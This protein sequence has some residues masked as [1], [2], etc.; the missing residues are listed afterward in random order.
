MYPDTD[1]FYVVFR[2]RRQIS[3][4]VSE[5][6]ELSVIKYT[7]SACIRI[8]FRP[9]I[10][11]LTTPAKHLSPL[12]EQADRWTPSDGTLWARQPLLAHNFPYTRWRFD[13]WSG[14]WRRRLRAV[15][16]SRS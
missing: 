6:R 2:F 14:C 12:T 9:E 13:K 5:S 4:S 11:I 3:V 7:A 16:F 1:I 10:H 15:L 8:L